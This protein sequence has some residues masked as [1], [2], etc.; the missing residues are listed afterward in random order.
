MK[1]IN[2]NMIAFLLV[3]IAMAVFMPA[4]AQPPVGPPP[5]STPIDGGLSLVIAACAGYGAKRIHDRK[6]SQQK[7]N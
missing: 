2:F 3:C 6:K 1:N 5:N 4:M 7:V